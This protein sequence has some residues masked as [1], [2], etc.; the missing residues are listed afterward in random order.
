M[1][2]R[3]FMAMLTGGIVVAPLAAE[4]QQAGR[5]WRIGW[6]AFGP[7]GPD[8]MPPEFVR[9]FEELG[10]VRGRNLVIEIRGHPDQARLPALAREL[11]LLGVDL[12]VPDLAAFVR[13]LRA[14]GACQTQ[15]GGG[16]GSGD[17]ATPRL[18]IS[19][20]RHPPPQES[21]RVS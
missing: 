14:C 8:Q 16:C 2:R 20:R 3:T 21:R 5:V 6:L 7:P 4:A 9:Q 18:L 17:H 1:E 10:Y 15:F 19:A 13:N 12:I 11:L